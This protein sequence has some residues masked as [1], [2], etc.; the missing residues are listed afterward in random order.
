[1]WNRRPNNKTIYWMI[2]CFYD[3]KTAFVLWPPPLPPSQEDTNYVIRENPIYFPSLSFRLKLDLRIMCNKP[4]IKSEISS[5]ECT[6]LA[7]KI[8]FVWLAFRNVFYEYK[9]KN[10]CQYYNF[11]RNVSNARKTVSRF[12]IKFIEKQT[13][14]EAVKYFRMFWYAIE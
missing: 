9:I 6:S 1:M 2:F 4:V 11:P 10:Q 13:F 8:V 12:I 5:N 7:N 14:A 3:H